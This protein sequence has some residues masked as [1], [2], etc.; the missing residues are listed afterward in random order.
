MRV[1]EPAAGGQV[2]VVESGEG[3]SRNSLCGRADVAAIWPEDGL[4]DPW[5]RTYYAEGTEAEVTC[6]YCLTQLARRREGER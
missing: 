1:G 4:P 2:H 3:Q 6:T 5:R